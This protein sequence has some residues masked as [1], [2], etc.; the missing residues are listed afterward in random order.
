MN[1]TVDGKT[2]TNGV[3]AVFVVI[4]ALAIVGLI[5]LIFGWASILIG[6]YLLSNYEFNKVVVYIL[7]FLALCSVTRGKK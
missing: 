6:D 4:L 2:I 7:V 1:V 3:V 5:L